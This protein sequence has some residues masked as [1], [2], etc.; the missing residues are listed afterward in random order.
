[1][2]DEYDLRIIGFFHLLEEIREFILFGFCYTIELNYAAVFAAAV[3][4]AAVFAAAVAA[5]CPCGRFGINISNGILRL[6][7]FL[8]HEKGE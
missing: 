5:A 1:M 6:A 3:F 2:I 4:A 7:N 8:I